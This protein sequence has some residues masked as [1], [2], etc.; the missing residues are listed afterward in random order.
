MINAAITYALNY[1]YEKIAFAEIAKAAEVWG[2]RG[3][4]GEKN[5]FSKR[6]SLLASFL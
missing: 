4:R 6:F 1:M 3:A 2:K 5:S